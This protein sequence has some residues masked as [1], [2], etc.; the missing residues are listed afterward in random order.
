M[1]MNQLLQRS[2]QLGGIQLAF[3][4]K[5]QRHI[6]ARS[7]SPRLLLNE[8]SKLGGGKLVFPGTGWFVRGLR[9][10]FFQLPGLKLEACSEPV[11]ASGQLQYRSIS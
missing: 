3:D 8:Y 1:P 5:S 4:Q 6:V 7:D 10:G 9:I 11:K 2:F